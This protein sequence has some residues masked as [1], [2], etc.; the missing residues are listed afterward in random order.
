MAVKPVCQELLLTGSTF[1]AGLACCFWAGSY[2][3]MI[4]PAAV[5][6]HAGEGG[7]GHSWG[8]WQSALQC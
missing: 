3:V 1:L 5:A 4:L 2:H 6:A 7:C 8:C